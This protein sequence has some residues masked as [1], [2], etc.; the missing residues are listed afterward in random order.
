MSKKEIIHL[1][2]LQGFTD[3]SYRSCFHQFWN[4][5]DYYYIPYLSIGPGR[6]V[7]NSQLKDT[8][9]INNQ[10][11]PVIPQVLVANTDELGQLM[12]IIKSNEYKEINLNLGCPYSMATKKGRGTGLLENTKEL[13]AVLDM[14]FSDSSFKISIKLRSGLNEPTT[15]FDR[16][17]LINSFPFEKVIFHPRTAKQMYKGKADM[18]VFE[19]FKAACNHPIVYNGDIFEL[20]DFKRLKQKFPEQNEWMLGRGILMNPFLPEQINNV[21]VN[22][23]E[24][25]DRLLKFHNLLFKHYSDSLD[26][27]GHVLNKMQ[28]FWIYF[29]ESFSQPRKAL[30]IIKKTKNINQYSIN[31]Q[32]I[33]QS[34]S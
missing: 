30:K 9:K 6:K 26:T 17:D 1:A 19:E 5:I 13:E 3:Y 28:Q 12:T 15:C 29:S 18:N 25:Y 7:R 34:E 14:L 24:K 27:G 10:N 33:F 4:S 22:E 32:Q 31:V 16:I 21:N 8:S 20:D 2:P 11:I 23:S